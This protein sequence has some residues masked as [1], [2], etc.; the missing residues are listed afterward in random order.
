[1][2]EV[3]DIGPSRSGQRALE[4]M[5]LSTIDA[6]G[7]FS[8]PTPRHILKLKMEGGIAALVAELARVVDAEDGESLP[9]PRLC[10]L[11]CI[12]EAA[13]QRDAFF[14]SELG[15]LGGF[16]ALV[17]IT[18]WL[19]QRQE[20]DAIEVLDGAIGAI[21]CSGCAGFPR[22]PMEATTDAD[23]LKPLTYTFIDSTFG[24]GEFGV[25]LRR[26][27][28]DF[29]FDQTSVGYVLWSAAITQS[30]WIC[31]YPEFLRGKEV[32]ELGAGVGLSG[33]VACRFAK[34]CV[35][36]DF[37]DAVLRNLAANVQINTGGEE[38]LGLP[39]AV[40]PSCD[41]SVC[42]LD[43]TM[44]HAEEEVDTAAG[45]GMPCLPAC[46]FERIIGSDI[47]CCAEDVTALCGVIGR[48]LAPTASAR[49]FFV[50]P[51]NDHRWGIET[52][53]P[54]LASLGLDLQYRPLVHS[55]LY[56]ESKYTGWARFGQCRREYSVADE[57]FSEAPSL[58]RE[59]DDYLLEG[60]DEAEYYCW[61]LIH[62]RW[63]KE[64]D[65][66]YNVNTFSN[67]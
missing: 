66:F 11:L 30:R 65:S 34:R 27:N 49:C 4:E 22:V 15:Q 29:H 12:V 21:V 25:V 18:S 64:S 6:S 7:V 43:W 52:F 32:L 41:V 60:I 47:I 19:A 53:L 48:Y 1:M 45:V 42:K 37:N 8:A 16:Q 28:K 56:N 33:I 39:C 46:T 14:A 17:Q 23:H 58:A 59:D 2:A 63:A 5:L 10:R 67:T 57:E 26:V 50:V 24:K 13:C 35:L 44:L 38:I 3:G 61:Q 9:V 36:T 40:H 55:R 20:E 31:R 62:C 54:A 51:T